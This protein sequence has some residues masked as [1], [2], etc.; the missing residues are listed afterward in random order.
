MHFSWGKTYRISRSVT[1]NLKVV[2]GF[3]ELLASLEIRHNWKLEG[4][5]GVAWYFSMAS[6]RSRPFGCGTAAAER[7]GTGMLPDEATVRPDTTA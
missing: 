1:L 5:V 6:M 4:T 7:S 3:V 2:D